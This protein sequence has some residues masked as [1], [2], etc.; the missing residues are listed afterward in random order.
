VSAAQLVNLERA[1]AANGRFGGHI[2]QGHIDC[3]AAVRAWVSDG[4]WT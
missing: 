3:T 1:L 4:A 2:V